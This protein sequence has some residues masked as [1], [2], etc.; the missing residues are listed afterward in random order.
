MQIVKHLQA[1]VSFLHNVS[2]QLLVKNFS[3][4]L[5]FVELALVFIEFRRLK[6]LL[7]ND[8]KLSDNFG[9]GIAELNGVG[10]EVNDDLHNAT[11]VSI[12][13]LEKVFIPTRHE[14]SDNLQVFCFRIVRNH[15]DRLS[16]GFRQTE[17]LLV[18]FESAVLDLS[19]V[20]QVH[21][22]VLHHLRVRTQ[23]PH[24][25]ELLAQLGVERITRVGLFGN[26]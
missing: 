9:V 14:W 10:Q 20:Q 18:Q 11:L 4:A 3:Y 21:H 6:D 5:F 16:D 19:Q 17:E 26:F 23:N 1:L 13:L 15:L 7:F 12:N 25:C 8:F 24:Q 2:L 22:Q